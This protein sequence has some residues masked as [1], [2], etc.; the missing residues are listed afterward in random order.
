MKQYLIKLFIFSVVIAISIGFVFS[1]A[2]GRFD[3]FYKRFTS[4]KQSSLIL[5]SSR[6]AQGLVPSV[7]NEEL[8]K[9][10]F[11]NYS[12]T[13]NTS[14][15]GPTYLNSIKNKFNE[16]S[17][18][19]IF[20]ISVDPWVLVSDGLDPENALQFDE[21]ENFLGK[22]TSVNSNPNLSYF[23]NGFTDLYVKVLINNSNFLLHDDGWL[24]VSIKQDSLQLE[25]N[26]SSSIDNY[27]QKLETYQFSELR[28]DY[29][30]Q[31][32]LF[33]KP[34][35]E[36]YLVRLPIHEKMKAIEYQIMPDFDARIN[37]LSEI[38]SVKYI[39]LYNEDGLYQFTDGHHL[40]KESAMMV[41]EKVANFI[42]NIEAT[43][44]RINEDQ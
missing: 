1:K 11:Y 41:S 29:L 6:A 30:K 35:G 20:I 4:S 24:E 38:T 3:P 44:S 21:S 16:E 32:I 19:N 36:V 42:K 25:K 34:F 7:F 12:F 10:G 40:T 8:N 39:N 13:F 43:N 28:L 14:P 5:G 22:V 15:F 18:N 17:T 23:V 33:L 2:D 9:D 37:K 27:T 31:T 26:L